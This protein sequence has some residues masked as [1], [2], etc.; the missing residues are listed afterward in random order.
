MLL[1]VLLVRPLVPHCRQ[2]QQQLLLGR[3]RLHQA[4]ISGA[5]SGPARLACL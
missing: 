5:S 3:L 4:M 1:L 2:A